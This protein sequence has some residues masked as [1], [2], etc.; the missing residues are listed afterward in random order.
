MKFIITIIM[1]IAMQS[2]F[3][4]TFFKSTNSTIFTNEIILSNYTI[5]KLDAGS[6]KEKSLNSFDYRNVYTTLQLIK[7]NS[8]NIF[9]I[10]YQT[11]FEGKIIF[12]AYSNNLQKIITNTNKPSFRFD[13]CIKD[14]NEGFS[15]TQV[16]QGA[17]NCILNKLNYSSQ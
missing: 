10:L 6:L 14:I 12:L 5:L 4:Q 15:S 9:H 3:S 8:S 13:K 1:L 2:T 11:N 17:V 7:D 16:S